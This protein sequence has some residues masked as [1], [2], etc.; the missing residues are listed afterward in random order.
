VLCTSSSIFIAA[1]LVLLMAERWVERHRLFAAP[2]DTDDP[3]AGRG[4][5]LGARASAM[6]GI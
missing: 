3:P 6:G 4:R 5:R 2:P 1:P